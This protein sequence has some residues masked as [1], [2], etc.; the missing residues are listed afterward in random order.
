MIL[1]I[2]ALFNLKMK[3]NWN[4]IIFIRI[5]EYTGPWERGFFQFRYSQHFLTTH[6]LPS[7]LQEDWCLPQTWNFPGTDQQQSPHWKFQWSILSSAPWVSTENWESF[8]CAQLLVS[9]QKIITSALMFEVP[10]TAFRLNKRISHIQS[11]PHT[12]IYYTDIFSKQTHTQN[13]HKL[14]SRFKG[15]PAIQKR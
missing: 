1:N 6:F 9:L 8:G 4:I 13:S 5:G 12:A 15:I 10:I 2:V 3:E 14:F 7:W 11:L